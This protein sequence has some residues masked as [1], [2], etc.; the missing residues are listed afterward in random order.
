MSRAAGWLARI[1][2]GAGLVA[3]SNSWA[4]NEKTA[5]QGQPPPSPAPLAAAFDAELARIGELSVEQFAERFSPAGPYL[6]KLS[7][8]PTT[9][10]YFEKFQRRFNINGS[11]EARLR[12][13]GFLAADCQMKSF[14]QVYYQVFSSDAPVYV[15]ADSVL[16]AWHRS[17]DAMLEETEE[18]VLAPRLDSILRAMAERLPAARRAYGRGMLADSLT[19]ADYFLCVGRSLL[20]GK[21]LESSAVGQNDRA[22]ATL[23]QIG[24]LRP[25][26]TQLFGRPREWDGSQFKPRGHYDKT[27]ASGRYFQAMMWCARADL[28]IGGNAQ[29][30]SNRE[31]GAAVVLHDLLRGSGMWEEWADSNR[32]L[33]SLFGRADSLTF[34]QFDALLERAGIRSPTDLKTAE[35]LAQLRAQIEREGAGRQQIAGDIFVSPGGQGN[36]VLPR[37]FAFFGQ[38]L[39]LDSWAMSKVVFDDIEWNRQKVQRR[40]PSGLDVAFAVFANNHLTPVLVERLNDRAGLPFR[41]GLPYQHNLADAWRDRLAPAG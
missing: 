35:D 6:D 15:T 20:A 5:G 14:A 10:D 12:R 36:A 32:Y 33:A 29:M 23:D 9:A 31:L 21:N 34:T 16:H 24:Q 37:S 30:A 17:F 18:Q 40:I 13:N 7:F 8:D 41:D 25:V 38:H 27:P 1:V 11:Q 22:Q 26:T 2:A 4:S 28:R 3:G 19:D 39:A